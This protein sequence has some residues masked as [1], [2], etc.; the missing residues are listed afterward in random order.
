MVKGSVWPLFLKLDHHR[1]FQLIRTILSFFFL[2]IFFLIIDLIL[3][4][5]IFFF[6]VIRTIRT[7][8]TQ[9]HFV[10]CQKTIDLIKSHLCRISIVLIHFQL[11]NEYCCYRGRSTHVYQRWPIE[12][13]QADQVCWCSKSGWIR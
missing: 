3:H 11:Y 2:L 7:L 6:R 1:I 8:C 4:K 13:I 10:V 9:F 12:L 5:N